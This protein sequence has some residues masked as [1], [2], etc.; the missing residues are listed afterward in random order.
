MRLTQ[1]SPDGAWHLRGVDLA[2]L[3]PEVYGALC[4]LLAYEDTGM[5][6]DEVET[7]KYAAACA[8]PMTD[9][10]RRLTGRIEEQADRIE[11]LYN[12]GERIHKA[13]EDALDKRFM[14]CIV[15]E[16]MNEVKEELQ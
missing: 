5:D 13:Y 2:A 12:A 3:P 16:I 6:P 9:R 15:E 14:P 11:Q 7:M 8:P 4:K 1:K 10:E